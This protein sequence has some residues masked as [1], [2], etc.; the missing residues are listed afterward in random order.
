MD[1]AA[2]I[3]VIGGTNIDILAKYSTPITASGD[4]CIGKISTS[5]GGVARNIAENLARLGTA[6]TLITGLGD[7]EFSTL[8]RKSL[9]LP[10]LDISAC[11]TPPNTPSDSYLSLCDMTGELVSAVNQMQLVNELT[12]SY[13]KP[14]AAQITGAALI[15][16]D[17]NLPQDTIN[18]LAGLPYRP[19]LFFDGVSMEKVTRL[20]PCLD[21]IDGLKCNRLEAVALLDCSG[22]TAPDQ[23][24]TK[25]LKRG[26]DTVLLSL[27]ADGVQLGRAGQQT[28]FPLPEPPQKIASVTGAG[29]ALFAGFLHSQLQGASVSAAMH[30]G[31]SAAQ[32]SL[33]CTDPVHP[34]IASL[35]ADQ[36]EIV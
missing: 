30:L 16:A 9:N 22:Q 15:V 7:D 11:Y 25:L 31:L 13:L 2:P 1:R 12:P 19:A 21:Q 20:R 23:L 28:H 6:V 34:D 29:D 24:V 14:L 27:G 35:C 5:A 26:I 36:R 33:T 4:S 18:W 32:L 10:L 3:T 8:V 17:C